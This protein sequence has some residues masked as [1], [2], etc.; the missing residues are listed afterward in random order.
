[1]RPE[2]DNFFQPVASLL[3]L[4]LSLL[5]LILPLFQKEI[6]SGLFIDK[7]SVQSL[8]FIT[9]ILGIAIIWQIVEFQPFIQITLGKFKDRGRGFP[10]AWVTLNSNNIFWHLTIFNILVGVT[11][12]SS[13]LYA[14]LPIA[15][16]IQNLAYL[17]FFL[18]LI[19]LFSNLLAQSK[20]RYEAEQKKDKFP[21]TV[22][23]T[24]EKSRLIKPH[25]EIYENRNLSNQE[26]IDEG[27]ANQWNARRIKIK[28]QVQ[29][30]KEII[31]ITTNDGREIIKVCNVRT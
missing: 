23:S 12:I 6:V 26:L 5:T 19:T 16:L 2:Q 21:S 28:T 4:A 9:L 7:H 13:K 25:I 30:A 14:N 24:L 15:F 22:F 3:G 8:S 20:T 17:F 18:S 10:E 31:F 29:D 11:F 27:I 1:M